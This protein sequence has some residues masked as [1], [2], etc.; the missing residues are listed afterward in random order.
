LYEKKSEERKIKRGQKR[1]NKEGRSE[2]W[3]E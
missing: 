2:E 3:C 1:E